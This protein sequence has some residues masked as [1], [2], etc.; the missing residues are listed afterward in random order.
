MGVVGYFIQ[1][2][3]F[4]EVCRKKMVPTSFLIRHIKIRKGNKILPFQ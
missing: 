1:K 2:N 4:A 3:E